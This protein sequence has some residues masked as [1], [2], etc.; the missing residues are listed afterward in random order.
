MFETLVGRSTRSCRR[1]SYLQCHRNRIKAGRVA[2]GSRIF[3]YGDWG[4]DFSLPASFRVLEGACKYRL[5]LST[6][7]QVPRDECK[8]ECLI[9]RRDRLLHASRFTQPISLTAFTRGSK[10]ND[11]SL[12]ISNYENRFLAQCYCIR[13]KSHLLYSYSL[14]NRLFESVGWLDFKLNTIAL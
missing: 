14:S 5:S 7:A 12:K 2:G 13:F 8:L 6:G 9:A 4:I 3:R 10:R 11:T 1:F